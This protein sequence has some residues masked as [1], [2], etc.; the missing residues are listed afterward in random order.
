MTLNYRGY[1]YDSSTSEF[2]ATSGAGTGGSEEGDET[3][4]W[5][6]W[7]GAWGDEKYPDGFLDDI[8]TGQYCLSTECRYTSGPTGP[9][10]KN[11]G[12]KTMCQND[13]DCTIFDNIDDLTTQ[14]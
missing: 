1:W 11:L 14:S 3:A 9:V 12:R 7:L 6:N 2:S 8:K 4:S 13:N 5:L 10:D